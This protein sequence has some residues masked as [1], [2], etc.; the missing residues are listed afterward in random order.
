[1]HKYI[2][3][4]S[5]LELVIHPIGGANALLFFDRMPS[6]LQTLVHGNPKLEM[7]SPMSFQPFSERKTE[8]CLDSSLTLV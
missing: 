4:L 3:D 6:P 8:P 1:M 7:P 2:Y 5:G